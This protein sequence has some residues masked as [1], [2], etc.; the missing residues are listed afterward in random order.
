MSH[1]QRPQ[2]VRVINGGGRAPAAPAA[3]AAPGAVAIRSA[4]AEPA[5]SP[6]AASAA[7]PRRTNPVLTVAL[8]LLACGAGGAATGAALVTLA[9]FQ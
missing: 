8:F 4:T 5:L 2:K 1:D 6:Q 9:H 7:L 3:P